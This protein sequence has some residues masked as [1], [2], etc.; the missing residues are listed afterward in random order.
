VREKRLGLGTLICSHDKAVEAAD[1][2]EVLDCKEAVALLA[3]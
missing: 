2:R 1:S 3:A